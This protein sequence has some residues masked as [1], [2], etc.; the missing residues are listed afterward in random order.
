MT[1]DPKRGLVGW[2]PAYGTAKT[3]REIAE[4]R[5]SH[6]MDVQVPYEHAQ[7]LAEDLAAERAAVATWRSVAESASKER[8]DACH[9]VVLLRTALQALAVISAEACAACGTVCLGCRDKRDAARYA[10]EQ[11]E[12]RGA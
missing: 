11:L 8:D 5:R 12:R 2:E 4:E 9:A 6:R 3:E 7:K 1:D 10:L